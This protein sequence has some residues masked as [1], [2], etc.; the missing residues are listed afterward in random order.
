[1]KY[2]VKKTLRKHSLIPPSAMVE[3]IKMAQK[4]TTQIFFFKIKNCSYRSR[5]SKVLDKGIENS[6]QV[7]WQNYKV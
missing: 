1:M 6:K 4:I 5:H 2:A 7:D 3:E